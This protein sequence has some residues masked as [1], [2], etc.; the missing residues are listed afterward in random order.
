MRRRAAGFRHSLMRRMFAVF[1][2]TVVPILLGCLAVYHQGSNLAWRRGLR[3]VDAEQNY[4]LETIDRELTNICT[5][6]LELTLGGDITY[7]INMDGV[8]S[9]YWHY[10]NISDML[11]QLNQIARNN[12]WIT[13]IRLHIPSMGKTLTS[14]LDLLPLMEEC[15]QLSA[16]QNN[17]SIFYPVLDGHFCIV[18]CNPLLK[19]E[20]QYYIV[21]Q[22]RFEQLAAPLL[23]SVGGNSAASCSNR[24]C[25]T[26]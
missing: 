18:S 5:S 2:L 3:M 26:I 7:M 12:Y 21:T 25:V 15:G 16:R 22:L 14:D 13:Q 6:Q 11:D 1:L 20:E 17:V 23:P 4:L 24:S 10:R 9:D 8:L 19:G